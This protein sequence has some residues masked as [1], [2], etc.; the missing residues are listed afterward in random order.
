MKDDHPVESDEGVATYLC[1]I[2]R[3]APRNW[4]LACEAGMWG[5]MGRVGES[6]R[7]IKPGDH[8][9]FWVGGRGY[10]GEGV[11]VEPPR[12]PRNRKEAPWPGGLGSFRNVIP[13]VVTKELES[14]IFLPFEG[15]KQR[16]TKL[17]KSAFQR[18]LY[19]MPNAAS[20]VV[21]GLLSKSPSKTQ[22]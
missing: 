2:S 9:V 3:K 21:L 19:R 18:S 15:D 20:D 16:D 17:P 5:I 10:V 11:V 22:I 7:T 13:M 8:L 14:P 12:A 4:P 1:P 6:I